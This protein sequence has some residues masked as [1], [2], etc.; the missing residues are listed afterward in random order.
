MVSFK[1]ESIQERIKSRKKKQIFS[2]EVIVILLIFVAIVG[3]F[4]VMKFW[5]SKLNSEIS[6]IEESIESEKM[7]IE[8]LLIGDGPDFYKRTNFI[9]NNIYKRHSSVDILKEIESL[10]VS[11]VVLLSFNHS[12]DDL[13]GEYI[14]ITADAD[15][16]LFMAQQIEKLKESKFFA[17]VRVSDTSRNNVGRIVF[18][19][20]AD[21]VDKDLLLYR[22]SNSEEE[23]EID[24]LEDTSDEFDAVIEE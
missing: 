17:N 20:R 5:Q 7:L 8:E 9:N 19:V 2:F 10:M 3:A 12:V 4:G 16:Y 23:I 24:D 6:D 11:R 15:E 18:A 14:M 13:E 1:N 22:S 21:V